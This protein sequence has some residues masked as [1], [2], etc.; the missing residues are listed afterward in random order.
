MDLKWWVILVQVCA[1]VQCS[2][3]R[4]IAMERV[5]SGV[6]VCRLKDGT[7][8]FISQERSLTVGPLPC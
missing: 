7:L 4:S 2:A 8:S 5:T 1:L 6:L 3:N